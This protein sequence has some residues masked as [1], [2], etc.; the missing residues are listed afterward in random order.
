M[1][2]TGLEAGISCKF[3]LKE[4]AEHCEYDDGNDDDDFT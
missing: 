3:H 4:Y 1:K 2:Y